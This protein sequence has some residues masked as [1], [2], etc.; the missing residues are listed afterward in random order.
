[1][2]LIVSPLTKYKLDM[3]RISFPEYWSCPVVQARVMYARVRRPAPRGIAGV[4]QGLGYLRVKRRP[5][6]LI[7]AVEC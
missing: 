1:M 5:G 2:C 6:G 3:L 4:M 7:K